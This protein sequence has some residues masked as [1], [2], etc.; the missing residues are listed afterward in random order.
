MECPDCSS[1][2]N[3]REDISKLPPMTELAA[4]D[5]GKSGDP[6]YVVAWKLL[7]NVMRSCKSLTE[8]LQKDPEDG[9]GMAELK[10]ALDEGKYTCR[11]EVLQ[12]HL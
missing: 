10:V 1:C 7:G 12:A 6:Q 11:R 2:C 5:D 3:F 4:P 9:M 8:T